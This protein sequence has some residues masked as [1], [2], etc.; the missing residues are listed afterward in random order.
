MAKK[1]QDCRGEVRLS[2]SGSSTCLCLPGAV[3]G[4]MISLLMT[5][6]LTDKPSTTV[7]ALKLYINDCVCMSADLECLLISDSPGCF[8]VMVV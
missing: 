3:A 5:H 4:K 2:L 7:C 1:E 8:S 6:I